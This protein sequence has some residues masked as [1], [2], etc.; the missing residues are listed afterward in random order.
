LIKENYVIDSLGS[1]GYL[2]WALLQ[3]NA[4]YVNLSKFNRYQAFSSVFRDMKTK[5]VD[6]LIIDMRS[7]SGGD[8]NDIPE[9]LNVLVQKKTVLGAYI[10]KNGP[11]HDDV[12]DPIKVYAHPNPDFY[13]DIPVVVLINRGSYSATSYFAAMIKG[14]DNVTLVGQIT[15]GGGGGNL[16]YQL[17]NGW[18]VAVSVS[19]FVDKQGVSIESGV[20]PDI[21]IENSES[22]LLNGVDRMLDKAI[23]Y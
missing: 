12:T 22:D 2:Y 3:D 16:G 21:F 10:E 14:L 17:S 13:F 5:N 20:E 18:L 15:G 1:D 19:D 4:G 7:N 9:L 23:D 8:S 6:K 11:N